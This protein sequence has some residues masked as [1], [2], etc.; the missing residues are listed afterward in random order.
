MDVIKRVKLCDP[1]LAHAISEC[2][3]DKV[4][5]TI[6]HEERKGEYLYSAF[7]PRWYAQSSQAWITQF[8][9]QITPRLPFVCECS[10]DVTTTATE[11]ADIQLQECWWGGDLPYL[12]LEPVRG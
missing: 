10:P 7:W 2:L 1:W 5:S 12:N 8:Y 9:L 4:K 3:R 11:A 6:P